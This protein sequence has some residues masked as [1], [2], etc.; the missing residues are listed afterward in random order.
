MGRGW[1]RVQGVG[2]WYPLTAQRSALG[3]ADGVLVT[4]VAVAV[5]RVKWHPLT[6]YVLHV[7]AAGA[8]LTGV[9]RAGFQG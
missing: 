2:L 1:N 9:D 4:G 8:L 5:F 6:G 3:P 7:P